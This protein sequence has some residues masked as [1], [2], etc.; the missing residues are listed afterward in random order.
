M[1]E[2]TEHHAQQHD[3]GCHLWRR[4]HERGDR[5]RR[6]F[7]DVRRPHVERHGGKFEGE[8][9][10]DEGDTDDQPGRY[11]MRIGDRLGDAGEI[12][13]AGETVGERDAVEQQT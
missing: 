9:S 2:R 13:A 11:T 4:A 5:C 12:H 6:A 7:I 10:D 8:A 3:E 1:A